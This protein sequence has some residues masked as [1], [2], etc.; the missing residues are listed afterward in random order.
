MEAGQQD[1]AEAVLK[2]EQ[3]YIKTGR[4]FQAVQ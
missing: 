4:L 1:I 2:Y 3:D